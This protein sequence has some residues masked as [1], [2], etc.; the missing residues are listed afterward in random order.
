MFF[1]GMVF[2]IRICWIQIQELGSSRIRVV[3]PARQAT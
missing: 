1:V 2:R 3:V